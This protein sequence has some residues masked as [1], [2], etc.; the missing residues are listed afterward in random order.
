MSSLQTLVKHVLEFWP[1][2]QKFLEKSKGTIDEILVADNL[3]AL[4]LRLTK[5]RLGEA[6]AGYKWMCDMMVEEEI[7]FR[8]T[9]NYRYSS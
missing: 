6:L 7:V 8:R 5:S 9:G 2:H 1:S 3:A 4:V